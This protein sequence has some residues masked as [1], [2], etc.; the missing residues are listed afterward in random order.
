MK[1]LKI[2][3]ALSLLSC[4]EPSHQQTRTSTT[5]SLSSEVSEEEN[6]NQINYNECLAQVDS[7]KASCRKLNTEKAGIH[8]AEFIAEKIIPYWIGTPWDYNGTTQIPGQGYIACGYFVTTVLRDAGVNINRVK[9]AQCAS[10][11]MI[12]SLTSMKTNYSSL[13][14][15]DFIQ[16]IKARGKGISVIGLDNHTGFLYNDGKELYFI[17]ASY[18]G[19]GKVAKEVA[20]E[21]AILQYS[22]YKVVGFISKDKKFMQQW[23]Q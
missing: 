19:T 8:F 22:K 16:K 2:A 9:M 21:N 11:Q 23:L 6:P 17:H 14:F 1:L 10:E 15:S 4:H 7:L 13:P 20:S 12:N 18:V 3:F 5:H